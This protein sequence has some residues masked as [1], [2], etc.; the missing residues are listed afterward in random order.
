MVKGP[1]NKAYSMLDY[2]INAA[3]S[4]NVVHRMKLQ[5][6]ETVDGI[7]DAIEILNLLLGVV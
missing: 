1:E 5:H 2:D 6:N 3:Q 7:K 4:V